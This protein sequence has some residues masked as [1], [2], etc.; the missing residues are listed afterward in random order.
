MKLELEFTRDD[1]KKLLEEVALNTFGKVLPPGS[2][3]AT[4]TGYDYKV[5]FVEAAES[6]HITNVTEEKSNI[7][8]VAEVMNEPIEL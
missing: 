1:V 4:Y 7:G 3:E 8:I 2:F 6:D 5:E